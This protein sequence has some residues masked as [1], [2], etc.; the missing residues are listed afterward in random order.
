MSAERNNIITKSFNYSQ[1]DEAEFIKE[2]RKAEGNQ[3][4]WGSLSSFYLKLYKVDGWPIR[5]QTLFRLD[6]P[7]LFIQCIIK[8]Q[9]LGFNA[10]PKIFKLSYPEL[11]H[12]AKIMNNIEL[13][14]WIHCI[15]V[16]KYQC[17][18]HVKDQF[19]IRKDYM[20]RQ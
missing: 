3:P 13:T 9:K 15:G 7:P 6:P 18:L 17:M 11:E 5:D 20:W 1:F 12:Y 14:K 19:G 8:L 10:N 16:A 4:T 2:R